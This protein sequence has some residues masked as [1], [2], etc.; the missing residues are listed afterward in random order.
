MFTRGFGGYFMEQKL[1]IKINYFDVKKMEELINTY[2]N[3][4]KRKMKVIKDDDGDKIVEITGLNL[5]WLK[6]KLH[7]SLIVAREFLKKQNTDLKWEM[8][9]E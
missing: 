3:R 2:S 8:K 5:L 7:S 4:T 6:I 1:I 9:I